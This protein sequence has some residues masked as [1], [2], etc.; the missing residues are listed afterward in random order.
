MG[1][2]SLGT[3][4]RACH[5]ADVLVRQC[6][7]SRHRAILRESFNLRPSGA[8]QLQRAAI[9]ADM[10]ICPMLS[11]DAMLTGC[12]SQRLGPAGK[13]LSP[14]HYSEAMRR[15]TRAAFNCFFLRSDTPSCFSTSSSSLMRALAWPTGTSAARV[16]LAFG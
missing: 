15:L 14:H 5:D 8:Q 12:K 1:P 6:A 4:R 3:P 13:H 10:A 2:W 16:G 7:Q 9:V 11:R